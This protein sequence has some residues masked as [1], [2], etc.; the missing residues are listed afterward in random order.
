[1]P[2]KY[3]PRDTG[4]YRWFAALKLVLAETFTE[5]HR[6]WIYRV[7]LVTTPLLTVYGITTDH[8]AALWVSLAAVVFGQV[9]AV[10]NTSTQQ[11]APRRRVKPR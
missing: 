1:M 3:D 11:L 9:G 10:V 8:T 2:K 4:L 7:L 5:P 6:A